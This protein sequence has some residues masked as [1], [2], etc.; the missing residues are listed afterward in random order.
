MCYGILNPLPRIF[1]TQG[2]NPCLLSLLHWQVGFFLPLVPPWKPSKGTV[3]A[4]ALRP[5][6]VESVKEQQEVSMAALA[7]RVGELYDMQS[8]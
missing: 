5:D 3:R 7:K 6:N 4:K 2:L 1:P 8:G